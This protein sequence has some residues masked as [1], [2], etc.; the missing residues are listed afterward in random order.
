M[1]ITR[2]YHWFKVLGVS[3]AVA[4]AAAACG[5]TD[6]DTT[7]AVDAASSAASSASDTAASALAAAGD[8]SASAEVA[9]AAAQE[10]QAAAELAQATAS[11][12]QAAVAAAE[13]ALAEA[14]R[15][16][17]E[18]RSQAAAAQQ[19]AN[20]ARAAAEAAEAAAAE[21]AEDPIVAESRR[22]TEA[23]LAGMVTSL[24]ETGNT[25]ADVT[26]LTTWGGPSSTPTPP[27]GV[28]IVTIPCAPVPPCST[29]SDFVDAV[30][31]ELGWE[32]EMIAG[33]G[34]P[35][36]YVAA[37]DSAIAK[38]PDVILGA[39][40]P[41]ALVGDRLDLAADAGIITISLA[42][43]P[44][45]DPNALAAYDAYVSLRSPLLGALQA[46]AVIADS[47]GT[48]NVSMIRDA[49]FPTLAATADEV[50]QIMA[51]CSACSLHVQDWLIT[52]A[53]DPA[54]VDGIISGI[55]AQNPDVEYLIMPYSLGDT[56]VIES[57]R[58]AGRSDVK[59]LHKDPNDEGLTNVINGGAWLTA[60]SSLEWLAWAGIDQ[61]IRGLT[62]SPYLGAL[63][64]G[65][66]VLLFDADNAPSDLNQDQRF[67]DAVDFRAE[68][69]ALWGIG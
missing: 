19:E 59:V 32:H 10:A 23:A 41:G 16:A 38:A 4:L 47:G 14:Q 6:D 27:S 52:D 40:A 31:A 8:A 61:A 20:E 55:L 1:R 39:A 42:D 37:F 13:D 56:A 30:A 44:E 68:Y 36:S 53:F 67:A 24:K 34:T 3:L 43:L 18:A 5:G 17:D 58:T 15:A 12:N 66:G 64:L 49:T 54:A 9:M 51:Q 50:E 60:A 28:S 7:A 69:R 26:R 22:I 45:P 48:A 33:A 11:G 25:P 63:D 35:E 57:L 46:F 21:S 65:I 62:G 2:R 29:V